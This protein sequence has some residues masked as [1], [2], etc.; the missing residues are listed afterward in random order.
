MLIAENI[1]KEIKG[2][3]ILD[4]ISFIIKLSQITTIIG[5]NGSGKSSLLRALAL[6][7]SPTSG[8][9]KI[10]NDSY[11]LPFKS[12]IA[13]YPKLTVV[14]QQHF[15]WPHLTV[16]ENILLATKFNLIQDLEE[17][18]E[19]LITLMDLKDLL[20]RYPNELS[21]GQRQRTALVRALI[22]KPTYLLL[23]EVTASLDMQQTKKI[24]D[25]LLEL[26][27]N[28][29]SI[30]IITHLIGLA[31]QIADQVIF[32]EDG[33]VEEQGTIAIFDN[34]TSKKLKSFLSFVS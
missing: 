34:P 23:D 16:K 21:G 32:L 1:C 7:D 25:Y 33:K 5:T 28:G 20:S 14:F 3:K 18:F 6:I 17:E 27:M 11:C 8:T 4:N 24:I 10:D 31:K 22:L 2:R 9:L 12:N 13:L 30:I 19:K 29:T 26:R 15:L